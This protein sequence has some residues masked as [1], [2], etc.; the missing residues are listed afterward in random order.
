MDNKLEIT[1]IRVNATLE[2]L[3]L[4]QFNWEPIT[5]TTP[6]II[7][8]VFTTVQEREIETRLRVSSQGINDKIFLRDYL[9]KQ[10]LHN[11]RSVFQS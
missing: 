11:I 4:G 10:V 7:L 9:S 6:F 2:E 5:V 8:R 1:D 3:V